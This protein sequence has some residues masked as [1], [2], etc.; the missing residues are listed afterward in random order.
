VFGGLQLAAWNFE[1][2][3]TIEQT[4]WGGTSLYCTVYMLVELFSSNITTEE[5]FIWTW[6]LRIEL[7]LYVFATLFLL[8]EIFRSFFVFLAPEV[9]ITIWAANIPYLSLVRMEC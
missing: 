3:T 5:S 2:P 4:I 9:Y 7:G 8:V 1:F 6:L